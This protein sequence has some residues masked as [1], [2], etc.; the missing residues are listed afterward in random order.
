MVCL[1]GA[2][3]AWVFESEGDDDPRYYD[4]GWER[5]LRALD[6]MRR[7]HVIAAALQMNPAV[8]GRIP[9]RLREVTVDNMA[10]DSWESADAFLEEMEALRDELKK[11]GL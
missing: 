11:E 3:M 5:C 2:V 10:F 9:V 8:V 4:D 7:G 6:N 1:G